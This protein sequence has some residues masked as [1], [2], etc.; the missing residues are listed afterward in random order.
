MTLQGVFKFADIKLNFTWPFSMD[1]QS[2]WVTS[3]ATLV[4]S[5]CTLAGL[6]KGR[7]SWGESNYHFSKFCEQAH[8]PTDVIIDSKNNSKPLPNMR[9]ANLPRKSSPR[10]RFQSQSSRSS[11][12]SSLYRWLPSSRCVLAGP[13]LRCCQVRFTASRHSGLRRRY[14]LL[15]CA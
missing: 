6:L 8:F 3:G 11:R 9:R 1:L 13:S 2:S 14:W 12:P 4:R 5:T 7:H 15:Y 10:P